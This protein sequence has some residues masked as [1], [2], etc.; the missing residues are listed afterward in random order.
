M[1]DIGPSLAKLRRDWQESGEVEVPQGMIG[2]RILNAMA[3]KL[4]EGEQLVVTRVDARTLRIKR[5]DQILRGS[6]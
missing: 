2:R 6:E 3:D 1:A 5:V 4:E